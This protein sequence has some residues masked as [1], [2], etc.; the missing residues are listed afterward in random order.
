M[1]HNG[2]LVIFSICLLPSN[3]TCWHPSQSVCNVLPTTSAETD[4]RRTT[5][6]KTHILTFIS[7]YAYA[8]SSTFAYL[9]VCYVHIRPLHSVFATPYVLLTP[10][11]CCESLP[12]GRWKPTTV[13]YTA[14]RINARTR[15]KAAKF[16]KRSQ[17]KAR[18][19]LES[20]DFKNIYNSILFLPHK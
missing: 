8:H 20:A 10:T 14:R 13:K 1:A 7:S 4:G 11:I 3:S 5:T 12:E 16:V 2:K 17:A 15:L 18:L 19:I 9:P 6:C